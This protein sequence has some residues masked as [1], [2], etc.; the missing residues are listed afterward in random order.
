MYQ[1]LFARGD[2]RRQ[3]HL[4]RRRVLRPRSTVAFRK[5][6]LLSHDLFEG[7]YARAALCTDI[8]LVDD[9]PSNYLRSSSRLHRWVRGDWQIARWLWRTVPDAEG[10]PCESAAGDCAL[11]DPRQPAPQ[12]AG[13]GAASS[14]SSRAGWC[15]RGRRIA[16]IGAGGSRARLPGL[17]AGGPVALAAGS[18]RAAARARCSPSATTWRQARA[19]RSCRRVFLLHQAA[20]MLDAIGRTLYAPGHPAPSAR[21]GDG[22]PRRRARRTAARDVLARMWAIPLASGVIVAGRGG[23]RARAGCCGAAGRRAVVAVA[24]AR[25]RDRT[26]DAGAADGARRIRSVRASA[27]WPGAPGASSTTFVGPGDN[28]LL[29]DNIQ[30]NRPRGRGASH[31]AHQHRPAA[32]VDAGGARPRLPDAR[33]PAVAS[34]ADVRHDRGRCRATAGICTTGTTRVTLEPLPPA[35]RID[36]RQRQLRR[37]PVHAAGRPRGNR[38]TRAHRQ[39]GAAGGGG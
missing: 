33:R 32:A 16:W 21:V 30:E 37:L 2:V 12:P 5:T 36:G 6:A 24:V 38:R 27:W 10:R 19:R 15:C 20:L 35:V 22:R 28:W 23:Y 31:L 39:P 26:A 9:Y 29:P 1:D 7:V 25:L 14:C 11:E 18:R 34:R 17:H 4:R 13:A 8:E 3:R